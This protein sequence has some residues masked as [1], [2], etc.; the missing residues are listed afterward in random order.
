MADTKD[1]NESHSRSSQ[2]HQHS[3]IIQPPHQQQRDTQHRD[4][5]VYNPSSTGRGERIHSYQ[6]YL[7]VDIRQRNRYN[8]TSTPVKSSLISSRQPIL[9][10]LDAPV[11]NTFELQQVTLYTPFH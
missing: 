5:H 3:E 6:S 11:M 7:P 10:Q 2:T 4:T 1:L 9:Y 8:D